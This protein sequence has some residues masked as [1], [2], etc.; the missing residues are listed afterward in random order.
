MKNLMNTF[1]K[2]CKLSKENEKVLF[3]TI[4]YVHCEAKTIL[5]QTNHICES[6]YFIEKGI[7]RTFYYKPEFD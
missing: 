3:E 1:Q 7:A 6:I 5:Q 4:Q 2:I